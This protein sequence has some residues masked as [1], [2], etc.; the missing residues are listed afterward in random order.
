MGLDRG[1]GASGLNARVGGECIASFANLEV[2]AAKMRV[3][4]TGNTVIAVGAHALT[5]EDVRFEEM[6][7]FDFA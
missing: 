3:T 5:I 1:S 4:P 2:V 7:E 6:T